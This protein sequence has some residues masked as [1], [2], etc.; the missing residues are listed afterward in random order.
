MNFWCYKYIPL[1][2]SFHIN[3]KYIVQVSGSVTASKNL[4]KKRLNFNDFMFNGITNMLNFTKRII[5]LIRCL[6]KLSSVIWFITKRFISLISDTCTIILS[7]AGLKA[8]IAEALNSNQVKILEPLQ[9]YSYPLQCMLIMLKKRIILTIV[10]I[11]II[12]S[13]VLKNTSIISK[14]TS[15]S[16]IIATLDL[17]ISRIVIRYK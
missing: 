17:S 9:V 14:S 8:T 16:L 6:I 7:I 15:C 11:I 5:T 2:Q 13:S 12:V 4:F 3:K 1:G 10:L